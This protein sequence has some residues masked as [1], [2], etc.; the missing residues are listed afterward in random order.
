M[1]R[2]LPGWAALV[3]GLAGAAGGGIATS[4]SAGLTADAPLPPAL[5]SVTPDFQ[6]SAAGLTAP[7]TYRLRVTRDT[8]FAAP[9]LDTTL[10]DQTVYALRRP[11]APLGAIVWQVDAR[12]AAAV[13]ASTGRVGP[14]T[15]PAWVTLTTLDNP[16]GTATPD[17]QP[18][19]TWRSPAVAA[20][21]GPFR[22]D[23]FVI[24]LGQPFPTYGVGGLTDTSFTITEPLER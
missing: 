16:Q 3:L 23:M 8:A 9:F 15:V 11:L 10:T 7:V 5:A 13:T 21:P 20:P 17:N 18:T 4:H 24:R 22:Y 1:R 14:I 6:W 2:L 19:F 12:D